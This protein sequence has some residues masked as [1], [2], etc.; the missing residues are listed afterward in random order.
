MVLTQFYWPNS[1][2]SC[3]QSAQCRI[4]LSCFFQ[5]LNEYLPRQ[6]NIKVTGM[7]G[8]LFGET[9]P[10][11]FDKVLLDAPC[12]ADRHLIHDNFQHAGWSVKKSRD[13]AKLQKQLLLS[14]LAT[15]KVNGTVVYSTC[16]LSTFENDGVIEAA[17]NEAM[18]KFGIR[19]NVVDISN[20][21]NCFGV[22]ECYFSETAKH[23]LLILPFQMKNWGPMFSCK[24][25][26]V[27]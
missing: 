10:K 16:T 11:T 5:V 12:S 8:I 22:D 15:V 18:E 3:S 6:G 2:S 4:N 23:G 13:Y 27:S 9:E 21:R 1:W 7:N 14:A 19:T 25:M 20:L 26:R 17:T 24:L